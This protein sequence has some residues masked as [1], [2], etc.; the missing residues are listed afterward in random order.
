MTEVTFD[1][2]SPEATSTRQVG[3]FQWGLGRLKADLIKLCD[4]TGREH[5][6][7]LRKRVHCM[8]FLIDEI[9]ERVRKEEL[10]SP[11]DPPQVAKGEE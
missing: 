5:P 9:A 1:W 10:I 4:A 3:H 2:S 8:L 7:D 11:I 6:L